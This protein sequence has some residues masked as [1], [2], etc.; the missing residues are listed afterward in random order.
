MTQVLD[1]C[2]GGRMFY[3][4]KHSP[5]VLYCD[6]REEEL[7]LCDGRKFTVNPDIIADFTKLPF[8]DCSFSHVVFDPPHLKDVGERSYMAKKY[9][10]LPD[11]WQK[12]I[13]DGFS[14]CWRVL[15]PNGTLV[16]K[17]SESQIPASKM[18]EAIG[19]TPLYGDIR[20]ATRW[21]V[22]F[23]EALND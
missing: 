22:F 1:V 4:Q 13:Q 5:S 17:W 8:F 2:C 12:T 20:G 3:Y 19:R 18:L 14:E 6:N 10:R 23:K 15:R 9:G 16:M 11:D 7:T 21:L